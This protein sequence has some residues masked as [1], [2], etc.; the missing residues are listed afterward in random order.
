MTPAE[1]ELWRQADGILED[2][3]DLPQAQRAVQ[4]DALALAPELRARVERLLAAHDTGE[5]LLDRPP[6]TAPT[7]DFAGRR[8]GRWQLECE[9]GRG[10]MAVVYRARSLEG[11]AGQDAALKLLTLGALAASGR[12]RFLREQQALL[13]LRHPYIAPLYDA[14]VADDGTPWLAMARVEGERIDAWCEA[15]AL[16]AAARVRLLLQVCEAVAHA[17]R[18]LVIHRDIKPSNVLVDGDGR[19]RLLDFGIARFADAGEESTRTGLRALTPEYAAPE[20]FAGAAAATT[21]DVYGIGALL[22]RL[23]AGVP[24][25]GAGAR[26][27]SAPPAAPSRVAQQRAQAEGDA[28]PRSPRSTGSDLDAIVLKALAAEPEARYPGV[29]ALA[30]DLTRWLDGLPV[31][32]QPPSLRYRMRKFAAR[33]RLPIAA[34]AAVLIAILAGSAAAL[35]QAQRAQ[36]MATLAQAAQQRTEAA[37]KRSNAI[38]DFLFDLFRS[39]SPDRPREQLPTTAEV[40]AEAVRRAPERFAGDRETQAEFLAALARVY[41]D[42]GMAEGVELH[43]RVLALRAARREEDPRAYALAQ[44]RLAG[45]I[46]HTHQEEA[47][48]LLAEA[49]PALERIAPGSRDLVRAYRARI[50]LDMQM[51]DGAA[52]LRDSI[53]VRDLLLR[54]PDA[55]APERF[56]AAGIVA[57]GHHQAGNYAQALADYDLAMDLGE[58]A[59]D[60]LDRDLVTVRANRAGVLSH[61]GRFAAAETEFLA[62]NRDYARI[63]ARPRAYMFV[64]LRELELIYVRQGRYADALRMRDEWDRLLREPP[65]DE[66]DAKERAKS[67][68]WRANVLAR[69]GERKRAMALLDASMPHFRETGT[70]AR[71]RLIGLNT[72]IRILCDAQSPKPPQDALQ[73]ALELAGSMRGDKLVHA[74]EAHALAGLCA[75]RS[76]R[77]Q[78]A[79]ARLDRASALDARLPPGDAAAV[80]EHLLWRGEAQQKLGNHAGAREAWADALRRLSAPGFAG[81]PLRATLTARME[82]GPMAAG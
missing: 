80:A 38:R 77:P 6:A 1:R 21:M 68:L 81:H 26:E 55:T 48:R 14:G 11:P 16:D 66:D 63:F 3:L 34:A 67:Q 59:F 5:G 35:W 10:G 41:S 61:L 30:D 32:A 28:R 45:V 75:L 18:N 47:S 71:N 49:I 15:H 69:T 73:L 4:L 19:V 70:R 13:R 22:Y 58:R 7:D 25:R 29:D 42:R 40:F 79:L 52:R 50:T 36:R 37:L 78:A 39:T 20:Q 17:H 23:L 9:I 54:L 74:A 56:R 57:A 76:G 43:R 33:H 2:L 62:T 65:A 27:H 51:G 53:R 46:A 82:G 12:E 64:N 24:P 44:A 31:R 72:R 8:L 60:Y